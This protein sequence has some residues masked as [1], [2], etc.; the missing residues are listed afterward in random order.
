[1]SRLRHLV[2]KSVQSGVRYSI[3]SGHSRKGKNRECPA[4]N[5]SRVESSI[6]VPSLTELSPFRVRSRAFSFSLLVVVSVL[7]SPG[8]DYDKR[9][10][11]GW[12]TFRSRGRPDRIENTRPGLPFFLSRFSPADQAS[13]KQWMRVPRSRLVRTLA[14]Y[15]Q[16][17]KSE[18]SYGM[19]PVHGLQEEFWSREPIP[20]RRVG[21]WFTSSIFPDRMCGTCSQFFPSEMP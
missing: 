13:S 21:E 20:K 6:G 14:H 5:K 9:S 12:R 3:L 4:P 11:V 2:L 15:D 18:L 17:G 1:M 8:V 19:F 7:G 16:G 10:Q